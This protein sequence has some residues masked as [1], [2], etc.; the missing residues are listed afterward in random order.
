MRN[1]FVSEYQPFRARRAANGHP[2]ERGCS[3]QSHAGAREAEVWQP[4]QTDVL[5]RFDGPEHRQIGDLAVGKLPTTIVYD[6]RG[7]TLTFGEMI[8]L[9]GDLFDDYFEIKELSRTVL[10]RQQLRWALWMAMG[11]TG[12][13]PYADPA[14]K[15]RV[16]E[17]YLALAGRNISHYSAGGTA[18]ATYFKW[19]SIALVNAL[20]AGIESSEKHWREALSREAFALHFLTDS[21]SSGHVRTPRREMEEWYTQKFPDAVNRFVNRF[22]SFMYA[23][24]KKRN[25]ELRVSGAI[26]VVQY[27]PK[28]FTERNS[29]NDLGRQMKKFSLD[30]PIALALHDIDN[31]QG[32]PVISAVD[33]SGR[34][35]K[36]GYRWTA[37]GDGKLG[38]PD[39]RSKR[40]ETR[41]MLVSAVK[42]SMNDLSLVRA[43][44]AKHRGRKLSQPQRLAIIKMALGVKPGTLWN[45]VAAGAYL[46]KEDK[47]RSTPAPEWRWGKLAPQVYGRV[48]HAIKTRFADAFFKK[49]AAARRQGPTTALKVIKIGG[50]GDSIEAFARMLQTKGITFFEEFLGKAR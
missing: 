19:H 36:G 49:A 25:A 50:I 48:D 20:D 32:L 16:E 34:P 2:V 9:A 12:P 31:E 15:D 23:E 22:A 42:A 11:K 4:G 14:I 17:D 44:G 46:P 5:E 47:S 21:F 3:C 39:P 6:E 8:A 26:P 27:L 37:F 29:R 10:G 30:D 28:Y 7:Y 45:K 43:A 40:P 24:L 13:E 1:T 41:N 18:W 33:P 38:E 35:V